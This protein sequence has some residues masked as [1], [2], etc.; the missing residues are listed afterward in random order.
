MSFKKPFRAV[1]VKLG[2]HYRRKQRTSDRRSTIKVFS[3]AIAAG[4]ILGV[5]SIVLD[6]DGR[7]RMVSAAKP[8]AVWAGVARARKPQAGDFWSGCD[9]ARAAGTA[10]IYSGE[11]GY[12][13]GMDGDGDGI[14][15]EPY[16]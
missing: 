14:A 3:A 4:A 16:R 6:E 5:G 13:E 9:D 12:R 8:V 11:P 7:A 15:C 1:P 10:P 2:S